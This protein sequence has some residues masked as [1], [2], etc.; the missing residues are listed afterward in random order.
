MILDFSEW[1]QMI[2]IMVIREKKR[3]FEKHRIPE[4]ISLI[5]AVAAA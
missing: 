4:S 1:E 3:N 2:V 5:T